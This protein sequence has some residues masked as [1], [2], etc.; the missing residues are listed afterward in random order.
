MHSLKQ[1]GGKFKLDAYS[2][3]FYKHLRFTKAV[4]K[5][6]FITTN[7]TQLHPSLK[8]TTAA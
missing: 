4:G 5:D 1:S 6:N 8:T 7:I 3:V 2:F